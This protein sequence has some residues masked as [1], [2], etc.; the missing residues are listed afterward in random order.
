MSEKRKE[1]RA[2]TRLAEKDLAS[3]RKLASLELGGTPTTPIVVT[4]A[5]L[6]EVTAVASACIV[7]GDGT[8]LLDHRAQV[9][10]GKSLRVVDVQCKQCGEKRSLWMVIVAPVLN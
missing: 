5:S 9:V 6:V 4:T 7:C 8:K 2:L 1:R 3:R 10:D